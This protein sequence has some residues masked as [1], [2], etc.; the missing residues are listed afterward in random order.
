MTGDEIASWSDFAVGLAGAA[1]ALTGL[2]FV[3]VSINIER[4]VS[5]PTLAR[6][7]ASTLTLFATVLVG[8][9]LILIP[10][11]GPSALG[12][13]LGALGVATGVPLVWAQ[14]RRPRRSEQTSQ[15][16]W[17]AT[18]LA[19]SIAVP[20]LTAAAG[21]AVLSA[22]P[23]GLYWFAGA[24][25]VALVAGLIGAWILLVEILR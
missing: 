16:D 7:A 4:V 21:V 8:A 6:L 12:L 25:V 13:E 24:A 14:L 18:R 17:V 11:Q 2:L 22:A 19:P 20:G 23:G 1:A 9:L 3:A 10:A 15:L 5:V